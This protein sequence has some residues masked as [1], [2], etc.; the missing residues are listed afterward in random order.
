[1][2]ILIAHADIHGWPPWAVWLYVAILF[3]YAVL[4]GWGGWEL[5]KKG[6]R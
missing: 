4:M 2:P 6:R 1:M 5:W 3:G